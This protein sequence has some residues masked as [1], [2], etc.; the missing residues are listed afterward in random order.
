MSLV[1]PALVLGFI[2]ICHRAQE[3]VPP[4][5]ESYNALLKLALA[6]IVTDVFVIAGCFVLGTLYGAP[7]ALLL[8]VLAVVMISIW[9]FAAKM[10][11]LGF[12]S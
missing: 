4:S 9:Y 3:S 6:V 11:E 8:F 7:A 12:V 2:E 5:E 1:L 10:R